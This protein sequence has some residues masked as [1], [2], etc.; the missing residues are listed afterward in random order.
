[1]LNHVIGRFG[2]NIISDEFVPAFDRST[3]DGFA[4]ISRDLVGC[5][6]SIPAILRKAGETQMRKCQRTSSNL[7]NAFTSLREPYRKVRTRW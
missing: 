5:S 2:K 3:V 1:M 6:E 7:T 4:V